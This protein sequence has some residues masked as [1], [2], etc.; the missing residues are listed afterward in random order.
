[1][2]LMCVVTGS[3][4]ASLVR[5]VNVRARETEETWSDSVV[6]ND[7]VVKARSLGELAI[8]MKGEGLIR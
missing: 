7:W 6:W 2:M 3:S 4:I 8:I 5:A 1:M